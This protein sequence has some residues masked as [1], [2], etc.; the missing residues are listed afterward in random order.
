MKRFLTNYAAIILI[1]VGIFWAIGAIFLPGEKSEAARFEVASGQGVLSIA[2]NLSSQG[3]INSTSIFVAYALISGHYSR[4]QPGTY[5]LDSVMGYDQIIRMLISGPP[6]VNVMIFPG[7]TLKEID[8]ML[9]KTGIIGLGQLANLKPALLRDKFPFL[10]GAASLEGFL[11]PDTY[12]IRPSSDALEA[13]GVFLENFQRKALPLLAQ[14]S[15][16]YRT[17]IIASL[18]EKEVVSQNDKQLVAGIIEKRLKIG[19]A[20]Q[21]DAAVLYTACGDRFLDCRPLSAD[22]YKT[23]SPYNTYTNSGLPPTPIGNPTIDSISAA[24]SPKASPYLYYLTEGQNRT[25]IFSKTFE[26][27]NDNRAKYLGL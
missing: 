10:T 19:M 25:T 13:A 8:L 18:L 14:S 16:S 4:F 2:R 27:H 9:A 11:M 3:L 12:R 20:L 6:D 17:L 1:L 24:V 21:I 26:E 15:N 22:D 7:M 23:D 5:I